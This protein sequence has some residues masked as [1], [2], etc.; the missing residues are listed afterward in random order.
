MFSNIAGSWEIAA[1]TSTMAHNI[2][3]VLSPLFFISYVCGTRIFELPAGAP[4]PWLSRLYIV[5]L[6]SVYNFLL[7]HTNVYH[8]HHN[9]VVYCVCFWLNISTVL[10]TIVLGMYHDKVGAYHCVSLNNKSLWLYRRKRLLKLQCTVIYVVCSRIS[11]N[12]SPVAYTV[13]EI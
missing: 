1:A 11:I 9:H 13:S 5:L 4:T 8:I 3:T 10:L 2:R 12:Y 6:W 7:V